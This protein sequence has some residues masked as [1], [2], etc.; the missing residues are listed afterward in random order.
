[1]D[2]DEDGVIGKDDILVV[3]TTRYGHWS[4]EIE[5]HCIQYALGADEREAALWQTLPASMCLPSPEGAPLATRA[6]VWETCQ[7][8]LDLQPHIPAGSGG[9]YLSAI[10][11]SKRRIGPYCY[12]LLVAPAAM[13]PRSKRPFARA[14]GSPTAATYM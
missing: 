9:P 11:M 7:Q 2:V 3:A 12:D 6:A 13:M 1:M 4:K 5:E 14:P 10:A 8:L